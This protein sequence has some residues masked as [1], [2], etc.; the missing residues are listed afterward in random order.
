MASDDIQKARRMTLRLFALGEKLGSPSSGELAQLLASNAFGQKDRVQN[1]V[2]LSLETSETK[3]STAPLSKSFRLFFGAREELSRPFT[4]RTDCLQSSIYDVLL[5]F[6][7]FW[8]QVF[9]YYETMYY[10]PVELPDGTV[11]TSPASVSF[12]VGWKIACLFIRDTMLSTAARAAGVSSGYDRSMSWYF[13]PANATSELE[14]AKVL[15]LTVIGK[16]RKRGTV[17]VSAEGMIGHISFSST[18]PLL[19]WVEDKLDKDWNNTEKL[20]ALCEDYFESSSIRLNVTVNAT[21]DNVLN[22]SFDPNASFLDTFEMDGESLLN[23]YSLFSMTGRSISLNIR[24]ITP[25]IFAS[26]ICDYSGIDMGEFCREISEKCVWPEVVNTVSTVGQ[27]GISLLNI[28][29]DLTIVPPASSSRRRSSLSAPS[30]LNLTPEQEP[31]LPF[32]TSG[33]EMPSLEPIPKFGSSNDVF[34]IPIPQLTPTPS[35]HASIAIP[36]LTPTPKRHPRDSDVTFYTGESPPG[37]ALVPLPTEV[38]QE[39]ESPKKM[40]RVSSRPSLVTTSSLPN[41]PQISLQAIV[42]QIVNAA[43]REVGMRDWSLESALGDLLKRGKSLPALY[44]FVLISGNTGESVAEGQKEQNQ[45]NQRGKRRRSSNELNSRKKNFE[46]LPKISDSVLSHCDEYLTKIM[47]FAESTVL[48][49]LSHNQ[50]LQF[51]ALAR[52]LALAHVCA[53]RDWSEQAMKMVVAIAGDFA[54]YCSNV[55][56]YL[57]DTDIYAAGLRGI[58]AQE[59]IAVIEMARLFDSWDWVSL[60]MFYNDFA[61]A[62]L[63]GENGLC[64]VSHTASQSAPVRRGSGASKISKQMML[65]EGLNL[66]CLLVC[67]EL[68]NRWSFHV[69]STFWDLLRECERKLFSRRHAWVPENAN[70]KT[71]PETVAKL[72]RFLRTLLLDSSLYLLD[73]GDR[74]KLSQTVLHASFDIVRS[75]ILMRPYLLRG[76]H[77]HQIVQCAMMAAGVLFA[78]PDKRPD[79]VKLAQ[80]SMLMQTS[81]ESERIYSKYV[82][83]TVMLSTGGGD[84]VFSDGAGALALPGAHQPDIE[85]TGTIQEFYE[86]EFVSEMRQILANLHRTR[87]G[88]TSSCLGPF[89]D[90]QSS[91]PS[92]SPLSYIALSSATALGFQTAFQV[93][94]AEVKTLPAS[95]FAKALACSAPL[96]VVPCLVPPVEGLSRRSVNRKDRFF[97]WLSGTMIEA[98]ENGV[99]AVVHD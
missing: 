52:V 7:S 99:Y 32:Q 21:Q 79:F 98:R 17:L 36:E 69:S 50:L 49:L 76:R 23:P 96:G 31:V 13:Y 27:I 43:K 75:V 34:S 20:D 39:F 68:V 18:M 64:A 97:N 19:H 48:S 83:K 81:K 88:A 8:G 58:Y 60:S 78:P 47:D 45:P 4:S 65:R 82:L 11:D 85:L 94:H 12:E 86:K 53:E 90:K 30:R 40:Q 92:V 9:E 33:Q 5:C 35:G 16:I 62:V 72:D 84:V 46:S 26:P 2:K 29:A 93:S 61:Y 1:L 41:I 22:Q 95:Q 80:G 87:S 37:G 51:E 24:P 71:N 57:R 44:A 59:K 89:P 70:A 25:V 66:H 91:D 67:S 14:E 28:A 63:L 38:E 77:M 15:V 6:T 55:G 42:D 3:C 56:P 54:C 10:K 73:L 74:L